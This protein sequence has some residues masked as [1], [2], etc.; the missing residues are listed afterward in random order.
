VSL[1][2]FKVVLCKDGEILEIDDA[3]KTVNRGIELAKE[4]LCAVLSEWRKVSD[5][6]IYEPVEQPHFG[7]IQQAL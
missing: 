6:F 7:F 2:S 5:C 4:L 3:V 1:I